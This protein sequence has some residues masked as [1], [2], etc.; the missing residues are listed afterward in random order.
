MP[1]SMSRLVGVSPNRQ[2]RWVLSAFLV[3]LCAAVLLTAGGRAAQAQT[4]GVPD[5]TQQGPYTVNEMHYDAGSVQMSAPNVDGSTTA[6]FQHPLAGEL[7]YPSGPGPWPAL[8]FIHGNHS[9][10]ITGGTSEGS[11]FPCNTGD[12]QPIANYM[13]YG[14]LANN[15]ASHGYVVMSLDADALTNFQTSADNGT[16]LR[17]QLI[18]A[19]MDLLFRWNDGVAAAPIGNTFT[20]KIEVERGFGIFGHSRGGEAVAA[21]PLYNRLRPS[22]GR[23]YRIAA[24]FSLAPVDYER[25][26]PYGTFT[27]G[28]TPD[29]MAFATLLPTCDGDVSNIQGARIYQRA[30]HTLPDGT[31]L[32]PKIQFA[33]AGTNHDY[34][35]TIW[36]SD[37]GS[38]YRSTGSRPDAACG[39][40]VPGNVRL[41]PTDQRTGLVALAG[42]FFRRYVG[43]ETAFDPMMTGGAGL[44]GAACPQARG[45]DC[46]D[47]LKTTYFAPDSERRDVIVPDP[48]TALTTDAVGGALTGSGFTD[49][50]PAGSGSTAP[51]D[52]APGGFTWCN[53]EPVD[54]AVSSGLPTA[55]RPCPLPAA[56]TSGVLDPAAFGGQANERENAP[57]NR[58]YA[59]QLTLAW[60]GP[61][62]L[63]AA[64]PSN[65]DDASGFKALAMDVAVNYFDPRNGD[66]GISNGTYTRM[67]GASPTDPH[68]ADQNFD[69]VLTDSHDNTASVAADDPDFGTATEESLGTT[70]RHLLLNEL[71]I[72]LTA[73][74]G[75]D[76]SSI[77][78]VS[79]QF[80]TETPSG[81]IELANMRFQEPVNPAA[82]DP[83][84][85]PASASASSDPKLGI[86]LGLNGVTAVPPAGYC[87]DLRKPKSSL[88]SIAKGG[89]KL[90][91][92]GRAKDAGCAAV[93]GK[94]AVEGKVLREQVTIA[95]K[96][97]GGCR[98]VSPDGRLLPKT[99]CSTPYSLV[100]KGRR[101]FKLSVAHKLPKGNYLIRYQALDVRGNLEPAHARTIRLGASK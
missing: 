9:S 98:F 46:S 33:V 81:S 83:V 14:Y 101:K 57:V 86:A 39:E 71:R 38:G 76:L 79:L 6:A 62:Q 18:S 4:S 15:L 5:P 37:D 59:P 66:A 73:F 65:K 24:D 60:D 30:L 17:T 88:T 96:V 52:F 100:A 55:A 19:S 8:V 61:A 25:S 70:R 56:G 54:F 51:S 23:K 93:G 35:N 26:A 82:G 36:W 75:V 74:N 99:A 58:S 63:N 50:Y 11:G 12:Q 72:P 7:Y 90:I 43:G 64:I 84:I 22:P 40:D 95:R 97:H 44:P 87:A 16:F 48:N 42:A 53:P 20:G 67:A 41:S 1:R 29:R 31:D 89:R 21:F 34:Y 94:K 68:A 47:E 28:T 49:S 3:A 10:C 27:N 91:V 85:G 69:V 45:V 92:R 80:G 77:R 13:G 2:G 78:K 32:S